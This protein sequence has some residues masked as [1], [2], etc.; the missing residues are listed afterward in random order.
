M[1][2]SEAEFEGTKVIACKI[3]GNPVIHCNKTEYS[4]AKWCEVIGRALAGGTIGSAFVPVFGTI[5]GAVTGVVSTFWN[6][7]SVTGY[8]SPDKKLIYSGTI[9]RNQKTGKYD[10]YS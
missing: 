6:D 1:Q 2:I 5:T 3:D 7:V 4:A 10:T 9:Y 8:Y